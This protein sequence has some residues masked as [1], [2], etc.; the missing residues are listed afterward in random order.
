M[1]DGMLMKLFFLEVVFSHRKHD[2]LNLSQITV[3]RCVF[4]DLK[5]I[6]I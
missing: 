6:I 3:R 2:F 4:F 1:H 5:I